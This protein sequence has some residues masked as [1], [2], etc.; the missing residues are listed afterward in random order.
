MIRKTGAG[1]TIPTEADEQTAIFQWAELNEYK[2]PDLRWM[3]AVPN[4]GSR[5]KAE[6][7]HLKAQGVKSGVPDICLP[8][9][10]LG[11]HGLYIELKRS[12]GG[13]MSKNQDRWL[14]YL[15]GQDYYAAVCRGSRDA[16]ETIE[17]YLRAGQTSITMA[18]ITH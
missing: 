1:L 10:R 9:P 16:I 14:E 3:Y 5:H 17:K 4:G 15:W 12:R 11:F 2:Y 7:V 8:T 18:Q 6:A 13:R